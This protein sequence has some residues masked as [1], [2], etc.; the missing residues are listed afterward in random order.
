MSDHER[1]VGRVQ[2]DQPRDEGVGAAVASP[3][4]GGDR[5]RAAAV[6]HPGPN[7]M[8]VLAQVLGERC[9]EARH[10]LGYSQRG[11]AA[12]MNMSAS[13][14]REYEGG[15]QFAPAWLLVTLA[16]AARLPVCWFYGY[17]GCADE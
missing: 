9:A 7:A 11:F 14:V 12:A 10:R 2:Q 15:H 1:E 3:D 6:A 4:S 17:G 8:K 5:A 13:W 16:E